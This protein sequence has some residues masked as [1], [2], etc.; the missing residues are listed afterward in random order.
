MRPDGHTQ[1]HGVSSSSTF[2]D[3]WYMAVWAYNSGLEPGS[4]KL[5]NSTGCT[6]G[7]TC[8]D[9]NKDW[10]LGYADNPI[11][12]A[13]PPDRPAFADSS[14]DPAPGGATYN[15][16]WD[17]SHPQYWP[18]QEKVL[19]WAYDSVMLYDYSKGKDVQAF[20]FAHGNYTPPA[21]DLFCTS[22]DHCNAGKVDFTK[23]TSPDACQLT[24]S[25]VDHCWWH[26]EPKSWPITAPTSACPDCGVQVLTYRKGAK[27]P[28]PEPIAPRFRQTCD[29]APLPSNAVIVGDNTPAALGCPGK[30][31]TA[32]GP[33]TWNF[34]AAS[35]GT[36]PSKIL[37]DQIGAGFGG[38]F[39]FGYTLP[40]ARG[41]ADLVITG[42]W[43]PPRT[44]TG[45][46]RIMV[47]IPSYGARADEASYQV[48]TG[49]GRPTRD[50]RVD[51]A[52]TAGRNAW[53]ELGVFYLG[54]GAHV[55]LSNVTSDGAKGVDIAW[56]AVAFI[57]AKAPPAGR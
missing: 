32:A 18:Y 24:G 30:N 28:G 7:P 29:R 14:G 27:A 50:V 25:Y 35:N 6:P 41:D 4:A 49:R 39:W 33:I 12:P 45:W 3:N 40:P 2:I 42:T 8:T 10:G 57:R 52:A 53:V 15:L 23:P 55:S 13:Y 5:G 20:A 47:A 43:T 22:A 46:T 36:Y 21:Y 11:N 51:Q 16:N 38:H 56:D 1:T 37:F 54:S 17:L 48:A 34:A 26:S 9:R 31:W 44:V 19:A